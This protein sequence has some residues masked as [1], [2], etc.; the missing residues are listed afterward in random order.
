MPDAT[1]LSSSKVMN[2]TFLADPAAGGPVLGW[3]SRAQRRSRLHMA[4]A[5][6][7]IVL[8]PFHRILRLLRF[9]LQ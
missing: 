4:S 1:P 6:V 7:R 2:T 3:L 5:Q 9:E 8:P